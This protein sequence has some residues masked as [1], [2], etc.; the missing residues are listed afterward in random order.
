MKKRI[1]HLC[2]I[3]LTFIAGASAS[4]IRGKVI[5]HM[6]KSVIPEALIVLEDP[7]DDTFQME[8][9]SD[10]EGF[11][12]FRNVPP[13]RYKL[14]ALKEGFYNNSLFDFDV[15][16]DQSYDV[17]IRLI[18]QKGRWNSEYCFMIGGIEVKAVEKDVIQSE[19]V[20]TRR[21]DSGEIDHLQAD[22]LGDVLTLVP[23][24]EKSRQIGL[25][26]DQS[27]GIRKVANSYTTLYGNETFGTT[28]MVD[29]NVI[30]NDAMI[31]GINSSLASG[32]DLRTIPADDIESVE[33][34]T[35]IPSVEYSNFADGVIKVNT[36]RGQVRSRLKGKF[37][38]DTKGASFSSGLK[39]PFG[40]TL[41]Y[42]V[43][44]AYSE[45]NIRKEGDEYHRFYLS[46]AYSGDALDKKLDYVLKGSYTRSL[47]DEKPTD[48][49]KVGRHSHDYRTTG[50]LILKYKPDSQLV[51]SNYFNVD[52]NRKNNYRSRWVNDQID[53]VYGYIGEL[54]EDGR[55]WDINYKLLR[56]KTVKH[57]NGNEAGT[58][59]GLEFSYQKNTGSGV[60]LDSIYNYYG[61]YSTRRSYSFDDY[62][63]FPK[64]SIYGERNW[65][66]NVRDRSVEMMLGLRYDAINI[67]GLDI[68]ADNDGISFLNARQGE[69]LSPRFNTRIELAD[70]LFWRLGAGRSVKSISLSHVYRNSA[71]VQ[72]FID[73]Q[74]VEVEYKQQNPD[75]KSYY[76][77][78]LETSLDWKATDWLGLSL[79]A[80]YQESKD[81]PSTVAYP[82][83]YEINPDTLTSLTYSLMEN[84]AWSKD[85]GI[86][87][88]L[89]TKRIKN[90]KFVFNA[91]YR[92][93]LRGE[94]G[95][96]YDS[97]VDTSWEEIWAPNPET[98]KHKIILGQQTSY[99][100]QRLGV[101]LTVDL[102]YI[103]F[104]QKRTVYKSNSIETVLEGHPVT[105]YQGMT[106][107]YD[108]ERWEYG[109]H[110]VLNA[111]LSK[112]VGQNTEVSL[113]VNN[114][115]DDPGLWIDPFRGSIYELNVPIYYGLE[116]STQW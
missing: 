24:V 33:V 97:S 63:G 109:D 82:A 67:R 62:P 44:Y 64:F 19:M 31:T 80:Y 86:E 99:I 114:V 91:T 57:K 105:L 76:T 59:Y 60:H 113:Y 12:M 48:A 50:G 72:T 68:H 25:S 46:A 11:F 15:L 61:A 96:Y 93:S 104:D 77:D 9:M 51:Y 41:D 1:I 42:H 71:Y 29:G 32:I 100:N 95:R 23:G 116:V 4:E 47:D 111:R 98:W 39:V 75:L 22:N 40:G 45:R 18:N 70:G 66:W 10:K 14:A 110:W 52:M 58:L 2:L 89:N 34:I 103:P 30:N 83:G 37:N 85:S 92:Y 13:G 8:T 7:K 79:T 107:W 88:S 21:I 81:Q 74:W 78:K 53:T 65:K 112:S 20:T 43:N 17:T 102:Q 28:V 108:A 5:C 101:W 16:P 6:D 69:F 35:G 54:W 55:E 73:S 106:Y 3:L 90:L 94:E 27:I 84:T 87:F 38:P 115:F 49:N 56:D 26:S 36:K